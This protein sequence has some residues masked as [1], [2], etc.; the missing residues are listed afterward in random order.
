MQQLKIGLTD[1]QREQLE[2][3]A[4]AAKRTLSE[5]IRR[6]LESSLYDDKLYPAAKQFGDDIAQLA[7][8]L[9]GLLRV[10]DEADDATVIGALKLAIPIWLDLEYKPKGGKRSTVDLETLARAAAH[11]IFAIRHEL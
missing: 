5:E 1:E 4:K 8:F 9:M 3:K 7:Q 2:A 11:H 10:H 6:R